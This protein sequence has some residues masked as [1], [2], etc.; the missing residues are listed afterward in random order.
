MNSIQTV[1]QF[2]TD[3]ASF[4]ATVETLTSL[5][6]VR[7]MFAPLNAAICG[8]CRDDRA[9][10]IPSSLWGTCDAVIAAYQRAASRL[11]RTLR[12]D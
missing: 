1:E 12:N 6:T 8:N 3:A 4:L 10:T 9:F 2:Q 5:R 11:H 7:E